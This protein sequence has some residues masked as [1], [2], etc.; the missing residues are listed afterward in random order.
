MSIKRV[1]STRDSKTEFFYTPFYQNTEAEALR[2]WGASTAKPE[3]MICQY[4]ED[5]DLYYLGTFDDQTGKFQLLDSPKHVVSAVNL[6]KPVQVN[7]TLT[8]LQF[9]DAVESRIAED[10]RQA[11]LSV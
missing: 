2:T 3:S 6:K 10:K 7:Q 1:Y 5:Y 4:P 8:N 9:R 11:G